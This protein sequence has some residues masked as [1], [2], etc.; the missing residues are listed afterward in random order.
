MPGFD[1]TGPSGWGPMTGGGFGYCSG[2]RPVGGR[3]FVGGYGRGRFYGGGRRAWRGRWGAPYGWGNYGSGYGYGPAY[4]YPRA[5]PADM[6]AM[7]A[8]A[9]DLKAELRSIEERL[10]ALKP[11]SAA[12]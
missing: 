9:E 2:A 10:A 3:R 12:E 5:A 4:D 6:E 1:G 11:D 8:Y 7:A